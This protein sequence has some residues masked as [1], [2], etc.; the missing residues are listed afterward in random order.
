MQ[1]RL[2]PQ[3]VQWLRS[4]SSRADWGE[5]QS[6]SAALCDWAKSVPDTISRDLLAKAPAGEGSDGAVKGKKGLWGYICIIAVIF[7]W[8]HI[9]VGG[10]FFLNLLCDVYPVIVEKWRGCSRLPHLDFAFTVSNSASPQEISVLTG[11]SRTIG[12]NP[13]AVMLYWPKLHRL[14][15]VIEVYWLIVAKLIVSGQ[16]KSSI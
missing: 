2:L 5:E 16:N 7:W 9:P 12:K 14:M 8:Q 3:Q 6:Y 11:A 13:G 15:S 1:S 4:D 10:D